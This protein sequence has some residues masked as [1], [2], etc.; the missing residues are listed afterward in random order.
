MMAV[1]QIMVF[2]RVFVGSVV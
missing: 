1:N 2:F